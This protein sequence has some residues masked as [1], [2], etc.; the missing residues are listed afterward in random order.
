M[1]GSNDIGKLKKEGVEANNKSRFESLMGFRL[2]NLRSWDRFI[3][4]LCR[5]SD[6]ANLGVFRVAFG[7]CFSGF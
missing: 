1:A 5:P 3:K 6:P 2:E 7:E 4:L